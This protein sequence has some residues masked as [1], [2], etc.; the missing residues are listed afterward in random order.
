MW[1]VLFF[2]NTE[3]ICIMKTIRV[4]IATFLT[5]ALFITLFFGAKKIDKKH[6]FDTPAEYKGIIKMW[7]VDS[8][9]GGEGSRKQFL[10]GVARGF[11]KQNQ[12]VL[13]MVTNHTVDDV[14]E[15]FSKGI[16][17][18]LISYGN[19]VDL[20]NL[21]QINSD[22]KMKSGLIG[23]KEF[24]TAWCRGG[25]VLIANKKSNETVEKYISDLTVSQAQFTQ[26]LTALLLD[27]YSVKEVSVKGPM[28]AYVDFVNQKTNYFLGTQRDVI[29]IERRGVEVTTY[30]LENYND[31]YQ[32][33]S[34]T[35]NDKIKNVIAERFINYLL[36]E[37]V[38]KTLKSIGMFSCLY[39]LDYDNIHL[40]KMQ[41][42][43]PKYSVSAFLSTQ[44]LK[45]MQSLSLSAMLGDEESLIK[46]KK[47]V[48]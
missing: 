41:K 38:Q 32:Y 26:P 48:L 19:G 10:L 3:Y 47:L 23:D 46:I 25:Y 30:P 44:S 33:V 43:K 8:F 11:E 28:D 22:N 21:T 20:A 36:S 6:P 17:P 15:N 45:E 9:E 24:A 18:D 1:K 5:F 27:D 7:Q 4:I 13:V 16:Y 39:D 42:V 29:R 37:N 31:L 34:I 2:I 40:D 14:F 35:G 12:G